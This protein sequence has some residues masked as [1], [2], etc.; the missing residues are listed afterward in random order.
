M[1]VTNASSIICRTSIEVAFAAISKL[2]RN[3]YICTY[4]LLVGICDHGAIDFTIHF[5]EWM[6]YMCWMQVDYT[7]VVEYGCTKDRQ[8]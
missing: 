6:E 8:I 2:D 5:K 1:L 7:Y 4:V 3:T